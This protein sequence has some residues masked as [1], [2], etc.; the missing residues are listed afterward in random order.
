[1]KKNKFTWIAGLILVVIV[2]IVLLVREKIYNVTL[3]S[4]E[5]FS[6]AAGA[7][8]ALSFK[9]DITD[10]KSNIIQ[11]R[12]TDKAGYG[13]NFMVFDA[14]NFN[15][16]KDHN[17]TTPYVKEKNSKEFSFSFFP[18][19]SDEYFFVFDNTYSLA[20]NKLPEVYAIWSYRK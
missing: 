7:Y 20:N 16:W 5:N 1:M 17:P 4:N 18:D 3:L 13:I 11:G 12:V 15:A 2:L 14:K 8:N 19:H 6:V 9:I 10:K